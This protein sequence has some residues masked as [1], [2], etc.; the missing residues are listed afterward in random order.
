V[1]I[2]VGTDSSVPPL[3][4][5]NARELELLVEAGLTPIEAIASATSVAAGVMRLGRRL[6]TIAA[7][8]MADMLLVRGDPSTS[9][10]VLED[11]GR[12]ERIFKSRQTWS[13]DFV[14]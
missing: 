14:G 13:S 2:A 10:G 7:G 4:G 3:T 1:P 5:Q 11:A 8:F 12:I 9:I 6:G